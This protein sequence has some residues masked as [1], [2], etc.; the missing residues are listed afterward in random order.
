VYKFR[1]GGR[2]RGGK[3]TKE[4]RREKGVMGRQKDQDPNP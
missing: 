3:D 1:K 2:K 4:G